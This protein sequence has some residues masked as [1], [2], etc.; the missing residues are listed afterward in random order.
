MLQDQ[1][2]EIRARQA[3]AFDP[4]RLGE[5]MFVVWTPGDDEWPHIISARKAE[6]HEREAWSRF[7]K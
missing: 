6:K 7:C 2:Q 4:L 3:S 5:M 1:P